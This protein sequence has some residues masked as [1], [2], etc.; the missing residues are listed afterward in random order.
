LDIGGASPTDKDKLTKE[1][2][3]GATLTVAFRRP[4]PKILF[5]GSAR[6]R[7]HKHA[8]FNIL[9]KQEAWLRECAFKD[10]RPH[11]RASEA[12]KALK[13]KF[14]CK[15]WADTLTLA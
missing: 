1:L 12:G 8:R 14:S 3:A 9:P 7:I 5:H 6:K 15:I 10:G 2:P 13:A 11:M 4:E